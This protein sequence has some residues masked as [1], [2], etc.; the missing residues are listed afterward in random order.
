VADS[1]QSYIKAVK[2]SQMIALPG[3]FSAGDEPDGSGKFICSVFRNPE[4]AA[5]VMKLLKDRD[6][7]MIGICNGFQALV[8][9]GLVTYGE[10]RTLEDDAPTLTYNTCGKHISKIVSIETV[11]NK[12]P[13]LTNAEVGSVYQV[14][15]SHGEGR[16]V[17]SEE[18][19]KRLQEN[20]QLATQ[21]TAGSNLNGSMFDIE[22]ITSADGRIFGKMGHAE[23][24]GLNTYK[25]IPGRYDMGVFK[26]GVKYFE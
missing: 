13:W 3:G 7:L 18:W 19:Y 23:R 4:L 2:E 25:N 26:S 14:A 9:L 6:G 22:G 16:F 21:Y 8:K 1:L 15:M 20:G 10:I 24:I 17:C 5:E 12:S 11:A